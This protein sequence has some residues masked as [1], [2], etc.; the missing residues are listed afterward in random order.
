[1]VEGAGV[2]GI[3][4][5]ARNGIE[6]IGSDGGAGS[7]AI[8]VHHDKKGGGAGRGREASD[9]R[10]EASSRSKPCARREAGAGSETSTEGGW[11]KAEMGRPGIGLRLWTGE[12][13]GGEGTR[14]EGVDRVCAVAPRIGGLGRGGNGGERG[15]DRTGGR[16]GPLRG[17]ARVGSGLGAIWLVR[18]MMGGFTRVAGGRGFMMGGRVT[19][20]G[21]RLERLFKGVW[22]E[23]K[24]GPG[25]SG[26]RAGAFDRAGGL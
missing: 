2:V 9:K 11:I 18:N 5:D 12:H 7:G 17:G 26:S 19:Y 6:S 13:G 1:M 4:E 14:S 20:V 15:K 25:L 23:I 22:L 10:G 16:T 21:R 8:A 24:I 3:A